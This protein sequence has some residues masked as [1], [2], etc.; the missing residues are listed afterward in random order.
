[1][2][3][4]RAPLLI[5]LSVL[6]L[7]IADLV[8]HI[9][10]LPAR[11]AVHFD[12]A[13]RPNG[14]TTPDQLL[15]MDVL[16]LLGVVVLVGAGALLALFL[17]TALINM[18]NKDYWFAPE[19]ARSSRERMAHHLL[20]MTVITS[21]LVVAINHLVFLANLSP[22]P[23]RLASPFAA[24]MLA[25]VVAVAVWTVRLMTLFRRPRP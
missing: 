21:G 10:R 1:M 6:A 19:R 12:V 14:W 24:V 7:G 22:G 3:G 4:A 11:V 8:R 9:P 5:L 23:P 16:L 17:P 18:P 15:H 13:G 20:W 2:R 25:F